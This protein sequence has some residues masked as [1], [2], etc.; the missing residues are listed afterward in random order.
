MPGKDFYDG[1]LSIT[2]L[3]IE[4]LT[5]PVQT[6]VDHPGAN[7]NIDWA[8]APNETF[9]GQ[10]QANSAT[11]KFSNIMYISGNGLPENSWMIHPNIFN[12]TAGTGGLWS[13]PYSKGCLIPELDNFN[14][15]VAGLEYLGFEYKDKYY[16]TININIR[17]ADVF[18]NNDYI[19]SWNNNGDD[20][21]LENSEMLLGPGP[22]GPPN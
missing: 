6:W 11:N 14:N 9:I 10:L 17:Q 15:L 20:W 5:I 12:G 21:S 13:Q 18:S 7:T 4:L 8:L 22:F 2:F 1:K 19:F 16:D 3:D